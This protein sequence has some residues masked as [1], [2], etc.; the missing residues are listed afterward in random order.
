M[1]LYRTFTDKLIRWKNSSQGSTALL[2]EGARR[3]GKSS[4]AEKFGKENYKSCLVVDFANT[5]QA[6]KDNFE[7]NLNNLDVFFQVLSLEYG[8]KLYPRNSL[9]IFD[10]VQQFPKARQAIKYLV[11]DGRYDFLETGSLISLHEN[12]QDI[13]IPSE[14]EKLRMYPLTFPEF[15]IAAGEDQLLE[16]IRQCYASRQPLID[17]MHKR[18]TRLVREYML[19]G[20]MPQSVVAYFEN[21][22]DFE[23]ADTMK[24]R[25]LNLYREDINKAAR[26]YRSKVASLFEF[27]PG[28]LSTHEKK[29][30]LSKVDEYGQFDRYD[31]PLFWLND[32]MICN[33][34]YKSADPNIGLAL[35]AEAS[36]VKCYMGDTGLLVSLA[37]SK[38]ELSKQEVYKKTLAGNLSVNEGMLH[39]NLM[40][41][42]VASSGLGLFFYT[43]YSAEKHRNDIEVDFLL[44]SSGNLLGKIDPVEVKS[45]KNYKTVSLDKFAERFG[46]RVGRRVIVHP[47]QLSV[48]GN[49]LRVPTYMLF[50]V[51]EELE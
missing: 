3:V 48:E 42:T 31:D 17:S 45:A 34:C 38:S 4:I 20:G 5:T 32:S 35:S 9:I 28:Y 36:A 37:F 40:A 24:R 27:I 11:A 12:V 10:E 18:A 33:L 15:L 14:E 41:Q 1:K 26:R 21:G 30:T 25:I 51:T 23:A 16:Y 7:S 6:V 29:V 47:K 13:V 50:C 19:V 2:I 46:A 43:H 22:R 8:V 44:A 39:E 49:L